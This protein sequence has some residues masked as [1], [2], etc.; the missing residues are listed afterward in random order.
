MLCSKI[1]MKYEIGI[2]ELIPPA[3][4]S[5][6]PLKIEKSVKSWTLT[7]KTKND[8]YNE[9]VMTSSILLWFW[10]EFVTYFHTTK[11]CFN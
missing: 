7:P 11:F 4:F 10:I 2:S 5:L 9:P 1:D 8:N 6:I 3:K